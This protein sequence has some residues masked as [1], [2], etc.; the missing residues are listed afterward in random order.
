[1]FVRP[2][3]KA[4]TALPKPTP[5]NLRQFSYT[6]IA[7]RAIN[8]IK[9]PIAMADWAIV[10]I[11]DKAPMNS[12]LRRQIKVDTYCFDHPNRDDSFRSLLEKAIEEDLVVG[13]GTIEM[14]VSGDRERPLWMYPVDAS[15]I[16]IY[17]AWSGDPNEARYAQSFQNG[18][19]GSTIADIPLRNDELLYI[20]SNPSAAT[21]FGKSPL[22]ISFNDIARFLA[23]ADS[24]GQIASNLRPSILIDIG[25]VGPDEVE[26][27]RAYWT[28]DVEGQGTTPLMGFPGNPGDP[29]SRGIGVHRLYPDGDSAMFLKYQEFL[30]RLIANGFNISPMNL[31]LERDVNR[32]TSETM[33]DN[34]WK[35]AVLPLAKRIEAY[36]TREVLHRKLGHTSL[37]FQF[38][39]MHRVDEQADAETFERHYKSNAKTPNEWR[40]SRG[41]PPLDPKKHPFADMLWAD[42]QIAIAAAK[43]AAVVDDKAIEKAGN[44]DPKG[45]RNGGTEK[46][47]DELGT[48]RP[49]GGGSDNGDDGSGDE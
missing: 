16:K 23:T 21:P 32:N 37:K 15:T 30:I 2:G 31:A 25:D 13:A 49:R 44:E 28:N 24:V 8:V 45:N 12:E 1:M 40:V 38:L 22:E 34:D 14:Q 3:T 10:P 6:S 35:N 9:D 11:D 20:E 39:G 19:F 27:M 5:R 47:K 41:L 29:K 26:R 42:T 17:P 33:T 46:G 7:R 4:K 18:V 48:R 43:G 36:F